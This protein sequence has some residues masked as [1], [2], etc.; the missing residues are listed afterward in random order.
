MTEVQLIWLISVVLVASVAQSISGFGFALI[1]V[2]LMSVLIDPRD[3]VVIATFI[4]AASSSSQALIDRKHTSWKLALRLS[5]AAY[6]GM[7]LGLLIFIVVNESVLRVIVG[8]IVLLA[9]VVLMKGFTVRESHRYF[10]WIFGGISGVLATSTSTNG[11]PLVFLLQ[12]KNL[13]PSIFRS[14]ISTVFSLTSVGAIA[15]FVVSDK[16]TQ[17]GLVGVGLSLPVLFVGLRVGYAIR[18]RINASK[19]SVV[20]YSLLIL[21]AVSAVAS[22]LYR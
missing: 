21:S 9:T 13:S 19:F 20:V 6:M 12:A 16:V 15:L 7:P 22:A 2:P 1:S 11:P 14:T 5:G 3:A 17:D 4:G 10:D 18:P 8:A